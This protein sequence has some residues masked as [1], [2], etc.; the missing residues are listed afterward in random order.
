MLTLNDI[1]PADYRAAM[2]HFPAAVHV[3]ATDGPAGRRGLTVSAACSVSDRPA[4]V[5]VCLNREH[6]AN[7][8]FKENG[9]F[10][11]NTLA[12]G[13]VAVS[14]AF[15][16][17]ALAQDERFVQGEWSSML[18]GAPSL[19]GAAAVFDCEMIE[20]TD[21]ATHMVLFGRVRA[22]HVNENA[23]PLLYVN[24]QYHALGAMLE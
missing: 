4:T 18:T 20:A 17:S 11:L 6:P 24:R 12:V 7:G 3:A 2:R 9:C 16:N 23:A 1:S 5:L 15:S 21:V 19:T 10:A 14:R 22:I 8:V 13:H